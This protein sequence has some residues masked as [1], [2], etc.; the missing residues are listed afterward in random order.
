MK[1]SL[2]AD[3]TKFPRAVA[4]ISADKAGDV[5][6]FDIAVLAHDERHLRRRVIE[7]VHRDKILVDLA[8]PVALSGRDRLQLEH[9]LHVEVLSA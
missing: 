7:L 8:E 4:V 3:F 1:L 9:G 5:V 6:P 2:N